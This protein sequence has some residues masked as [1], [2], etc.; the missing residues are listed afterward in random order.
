MKREKKLFWVHYGFLRGSWYDT[1]KW[2]LESVV[3]KWERKGK[4][5][6]RESHPIFVVRKVGWTVE[7]CQMLF[8]RSFEDRE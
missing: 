5:L 1:I 6:A 2:R 4:A 8:E 3:W 7:L